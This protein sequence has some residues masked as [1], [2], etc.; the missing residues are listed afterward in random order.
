MASQVLLVN[1]LLATC[2]RFIYTK[3]SLFHKIHVTVFRVVAA[4]LLCSVAMSN[5]T[6]TITT[7]E[8]RRLR[9]AKTDMLLVD[10][11]AK[12]QFAK[13]HIEGAKNV[14]FD[15]ADFLPSMARAASNKS[16]KNSNNG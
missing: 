9:S 1:L 8:L 14:P 12:E 3:W 16:K 2:D 13:D 4:Q 11:L 10:V 6:K 7:S 15:G 5:T